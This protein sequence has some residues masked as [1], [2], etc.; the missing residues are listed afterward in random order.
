[1]IKELLKLT[2]FEHAL[3]LALAVLV[4]E[5]ITLGSL[6]PLELVI[7]LSLFVPILS[8]MGSFALNDYLDVETDRLNRKM[9]RPLVRGTISPG[10]AL[11][12]SIATLLLSTALSIFINQIAFII[13][14]LF[15]IAAVLYNWK[16][17]DI[18]LAGNVYIG[19][20]MAIPFIFGNFVVSQT[21]SPAVLVLAILGF[22]AGLAREIVKTVQDMKGDVKARGS[23]TLPV[24]IGAKPS[25][26]IAIILY[27]LFIPLSAVP[28]TV[29]L[30]VAVFPVILIAVADGMIALVCYQLVRSKNYR[31]A[32]KISL[33]AFTIGMMGLLLASL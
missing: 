17:K 5:I 3:M 33:I 32:R 22:I 28:F 1:M 21:L 10:L 31:F 19:L 26:A 15:N 7:I 30:R 18:P 2:R 6:P 27:L 8:E 4:A 14:L 13:A 25:L 24:I 12:L 20:T 16:L 23:K 9:D 29:G 11:N